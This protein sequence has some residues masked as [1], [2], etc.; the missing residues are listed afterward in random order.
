MLYPLIRKL[1]FSLDAEDAHGI[2]MR[3]ISALS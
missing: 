1:F 3:G 2:G